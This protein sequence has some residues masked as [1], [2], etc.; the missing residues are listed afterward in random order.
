MATGPFDLTDSS[1]YHRWRDHKLA[2]AP[3]TIDELV[4]EVA[5]PRHLSSAEREALLRRCQVAN[6]AIYAGPDLGEERSAPRL[7]GQQL[8]LERLDHNPG[9]DEDDITALQVAASHTGKGDFIPYTNRPLHLHTDG[10]YNTPERQVRGLVLHCVRAAHQGGANTL[11]DPELVYIQL[12]EENPDYI[13]ALQTG[14][15]MTIPPHV[16]EGEELRPRASG[17]VFSVGADGHLHMRYTARARHV[18]WRTDPSTQK[19]VAALSR[20]LVETPYVLRATL[21]PGQGLVCN[22]VLHDRSGFTDD[23]AAPRL[24]YR[25]RYYDRVLGI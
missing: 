18:E 11:L 5:D 16:A 14:E 9:A 22:N 6:M 21:A 17:P 3:R 24:I 13:A 1:A 8:G 7:L 12:R 15:V 23:P 19:A 4:V 2:T 25:G 10:Y 20:V